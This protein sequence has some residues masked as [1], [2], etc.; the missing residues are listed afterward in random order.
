M[1]EYK[2]Y[3]I[4]T[5]IFLRFFVKENEIVYQQCCDFL[6]LVQTGEIHATTSNLVLSEINWV[7]SK[8]YSFSKEDV[9]DILKSIIGLKNLKIIDSHNISLG[10]SLYEKYN[11][12]FIDSIIASNLE[13]FT[14]QSAVVSYDK[15]FDK[16]NVFRIEPSELLKK[17]NK[18]QTK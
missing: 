12:K 11:I 16:L 10:I 2:K 14:N 8:I 18:Q 5:N 7:L 13:I 1:K 4:D 15:D 6:K 9:I 17:F 3:F